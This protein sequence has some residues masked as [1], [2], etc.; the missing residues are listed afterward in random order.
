MRLCV[1]ADPYGCRQGPAFAL[2]IREDVWPRLSFPAAY[3]TMTS[4][5]CGTKG[6]TCLEPQSFSLVL[7]A[8]MVEDH[9]EH[10]MQGEFAKVAL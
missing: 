8:A 9:A 7:P 6:M 2:A 4:H 5:N 10:L 1:T 3:Q